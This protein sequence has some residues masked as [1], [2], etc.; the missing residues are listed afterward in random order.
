MY[1]V[2]LV[3]CSNLRSDNQLF[4][5][6]LADMHIHVMDSS[7]MACLY[8]SVLAGKAPFVLFFTTLTCPAGSK[9]VCKE[10]VFLWAFEVTVSKVEAVIS[11][12]SHSSTLSARYSADG[13]SFSARAP[14]T[15]STALTIASLSLCCRFRGIPMT[16]L[17]A[18]SSVS[19]S[20]N[21][22]PVSHELTTRANSARCSAPAVG[23]SWKSVRSA[24][25]NSAAVSASAMKTLKL[26]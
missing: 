2:N 12:F 23:S 22:L 20:Y 25:L 7:F 24:V 11:P 19:F 16:L 18:V 9:E 1:S 15:V 8:S 14:N 3:K 21:C 26:V 17:S 10:D 6:N 13:V 4:D 5:L